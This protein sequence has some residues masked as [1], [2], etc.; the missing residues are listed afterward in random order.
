MTSEEVNGCMDLAALIVSI[1]ALVVSSA[2][3]GWNIYAWISSGARLKVEV[4]NS[5]TAGPYGTHRCLGISV[6]N[7]GRLETTI[8]GIDLP[9]ADKRTLALFPQAFI[10]NYPP[11]TLAPGASETFLI[12]DSELV[13]LLISEKVDLEGLKVRVRTG[14]KNF[15]KSLPEAVVSRLRSDMNKYQPETEGQES[16][17]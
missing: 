8:S 17:A 4:S 14:H 10:V 2:S 3:V 6:A 13:P 7:A 16:G 15:V 1:V 11:K 5:V 12:P 9:L